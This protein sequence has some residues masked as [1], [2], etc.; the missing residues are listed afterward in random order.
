MLRRSVLAQ[1]LIG[2][3]LFLLAGCKLFGGNAGG[4]GLYLDNELLLKAAPPTVSRRALVLASGPHTLTVKGDAGTSYVLEGRVTGEGTL[5]VALGAA[6]KVAFTGALRHG[7]TTVSSGTAD[8]TGADVA[9]ETLHVQDAG[10]ALRRLTPADLTGMRLWLNGA[11]AESFVTTPSEDDADMGTTDAGTIVYRWVNLV[12][13]NNP[14][15]MLSGL[16]LRVTGE[17]ALTLDTS[18]LVLKNLKLHADA[19]VIAVVTTTRITMGIPA[20]FSTKL[21]PSDI[22]ADTEPVP[23]ALT[24]PPTRE[25]MNN[26]VVAGVFDPRAAYQWTTSEQRPIP[27]NQKLLLGAVRSEAGIALV[28]GGE[29]VP[30]PKASW[31]PFAETKAPTFIGRRWD[32]PDY[33]HGK[34]FEILA[35]EGADQV[36]ELVGYAAWHNGLEAGLPKEHPY[37][38]H[39]P[40]VK[41]VAAGAFIALPDG[42]TKP[43]HE[44]APPPTADA[45]E[46]KRE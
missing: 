39:P 18:A 8:F 17:N 10:T 25:G 3:T 46:S 11:D 43:V 36:H 4:D 44:L 38:L 41:V 34:Y 16:P 21:T 14:A 33:W 6:D 9:P 37:K 42:G 15:V 20:I 2:G 31:K 45:G 19:T 32:M 7:G 23:L 24:A 1:L 12:D 26:M 30:S 35:S 5:T 27:L 22:L 40:T 28:Y 29:L 13:A